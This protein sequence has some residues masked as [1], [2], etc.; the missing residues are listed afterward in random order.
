[1]A[2]NETRSRRKVRVGVGGNPLVAFPAAVNRDDVDELGQT[3]L[4]RLS[5]H[6]DS[7]R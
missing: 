2:E 1:M 5:N 6:P 3:D 7:A 4:A